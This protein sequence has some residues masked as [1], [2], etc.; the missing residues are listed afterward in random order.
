M[1]KEEDDIDFEDDL[2]YIENT[3][4]DEF[5]LLFYIALLRDNDHKASDYPL[6]LAL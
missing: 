2:Q 5:S 6:T 3:L 4:A 1:Y